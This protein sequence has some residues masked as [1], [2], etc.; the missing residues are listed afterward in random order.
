MNRTYKHVWKKFI[1]ML[2]QAN[3]PLFWMLIS[4]LAGIASSWFALKQPEYISEIVAGKFEVGFVCVMLLFSLGQCVCTLIANYIKNVTI[5][6]IDRNMEKMASR[7]V[8]SLPVST[9][10][11]QDPQKLIS[12][13]TT[14]SN[15]LSTFLLDMTVAELPRL[16]YMISAFVI[17]C[18]DYNIKLALAALL[19]I[20][21]TVI[22]A[23]IN[24]ALIF[25]KADKVQ[26]E[27]SALTGH[28]SEKI[29]NLP[30]I[31]AYTNEERE[32]REGGR[33]LDN[34]M[35]AKNKKAWID[36][37]NTQLS[38]AFGK[39][40]NFFVTAVGAVLILNG[41][42]TSGIFVGYFLYA[43]K[44]CTYVTEHIRLWISMKTAQGATYR[45]AGIMDEKEESQEGISEQL[46]G[47][48]VSDHVTFAYGD[49]KILDDVSF[50]VEEGKLTAFVGYSGCGKTTALNLI[51]RFYE[52]KQGKI[53]VGGKDISQWGMKY[54]P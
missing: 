6:K 51:E 41:E 37:V 9:L 14:D 39:L 40:P 25:G 1:E 24:G 12:R 19:T 50:T 22:G 7:K 29:V 16:Y 4:M 31:K 15:M 34:L 8:L 38:E 5:A 23:F 45:L 30:L 52:P 18:R 21:L 43:S 20:P 46:K 32:S 17:L 33:L 54:I 3:L 28:L 10:E 35:K 2:K 53:T 36:Q 27:I 49:K 26:A 11:G 13:I 44:V 42:I 47:D 48:V